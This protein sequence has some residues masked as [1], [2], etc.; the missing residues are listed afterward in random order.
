MIKLIKKWLGVSMLEDSIIDTNK[1]IFILTKKVGISPEEM[2][3][4]SVE[5]RSEFTDYMYQR[6]IANTSIGLSIATETSDVDRLVKIRELI[7]KIK[8]HKENNDTNAKVE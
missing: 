2:S 6:I 3:R 1:D 8:E 4:S 7:N 5:L